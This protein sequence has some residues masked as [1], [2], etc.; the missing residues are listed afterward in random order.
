[1]SNFIDK[2]GE[3]NG[4]VLQ[5][6]EENK[7]TRKRG[8]KEL[9]GLLFKPEGNNYFLKSITLLKGVCIFWH[10]KGLIGLYSNI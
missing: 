5:L 6:R 10:L 1:M 9:K 7:M 3:I 4:A 8:I 2:Y